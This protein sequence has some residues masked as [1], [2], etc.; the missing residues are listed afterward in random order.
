MQ[1]QFL[2]SFPVLVAPTLSKPL[3]GRANDLAQDLQILRSGVVLNWVVRMKEFIDLTVVSRTFR[4]FGCKREANLLID[5][6]NFVDILNVC[7]RVRQKMSKNVR[8]LDR[9]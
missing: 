5:S 1:E 3:K 4:C 9:H 7:F 2:R 8:I 6:Q